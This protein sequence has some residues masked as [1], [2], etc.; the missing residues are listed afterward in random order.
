MRGVNFLSIV[1]SLFVL[2][3]VAARAE[4]PVEIEN[5]WVRAVPPGSTAT[6]AYMRIRNPKSTPIMLTAA[7][8]SFAEIV[9]PM[10]TVRKEVDGKEVSGMEF[11]DALEI[12]AHG[13]AILEPGG[14]HL[15]FMKM[16]AVPAAGDITEVTLIFEPGATEVTIEMP[17]SRTAPE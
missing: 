10:I 4:T 16:T 9:R 8:V 3:Q 1:G 7:K 6:A 5:A 17:V 14:D 2:T 12:P 11:V 15:M 13:E